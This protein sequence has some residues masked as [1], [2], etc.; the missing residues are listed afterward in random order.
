MFQTTSGPDILPSFAEEC[1]FGNLAIGL[2]YLRK[3]L[4][5]SQRHGH[6]STEAKHHVVNGYQPAASLLLFDADIS[7]PEA[8]AVVSA[9]LHLRQVHLPSMPASHCLQWSEVSPLL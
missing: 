5:V 6:L 2:I 3:Q 7:G 4:Q 8:Q 1:G 9:I